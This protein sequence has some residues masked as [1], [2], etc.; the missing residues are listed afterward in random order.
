MKAFTVIRCLLAAATLIPALVS[1]ATSADL[2]LHNGKVWTVETKQPVAQAVAVAGN[3]IVK[4]GSDAQVL[5]LRG[6]NT[7]TRR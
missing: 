2:I 1:A 4:V 3:K 5:A 6:A 7:R